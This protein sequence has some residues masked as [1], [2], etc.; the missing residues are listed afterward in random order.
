VFPSEV[1]GVI[2]THPSV[3]EAA[4]VGAEHPLWGEAVVA[5]VVPAAGASID[6]SALKAHCRQALAG[7]KVPKQVVVRSE[8]LPRT[9]TGKVLRREL[10]REV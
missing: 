7:Y 9:S 1:E 8:P 4:V 2:V 5:I 3:A 6:P 10:R